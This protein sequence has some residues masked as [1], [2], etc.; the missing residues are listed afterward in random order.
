MPF[1]M[2]QD[3]YLPQIL[4]R[5][6][7]RFGTPW[8]AIL[9]S[10]GVYGLLAFQTLTRLITIYMWLRIATSLL[11]VLSAWQLRRK[12]ADMPRPFVIPGGRL[13]LLYAV[14]A[15]V[16][17]SVVAML[18]SDRYG[19]LWGPVALALGPLVYAIVRKTGRV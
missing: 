17:M 7:P 16:V 19:L 2:A 8:M 6:H 18:G 15:P 3:G 1:A 11:T 13:G 4:T 10:A 9:I 5:R 14:G 12:Q